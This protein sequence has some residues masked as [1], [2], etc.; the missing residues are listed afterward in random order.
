MKD[1]FDTMPRPALPA[2]PEYERRPRPM[3]PRPVDW[4]GPGP[5]T[6]VGAP[7]QTVTTEPADPAIKPDKGHFDGSCNRRACQRPIKGNGWFNRWTI[8]Y[9][10]QPCAFKINDADD[11]ES[12]R[13][14]GRGVP[15]RRVT[16]P[17]DLAD[18]HGS[19]S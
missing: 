2:H 9:Y 17:V 6:D 15:C 4:P 5:V 14:D 19:S 11:G 8:A 10:C 3:P 16:A 18:V 12:D 7:Q 1:L 13:V